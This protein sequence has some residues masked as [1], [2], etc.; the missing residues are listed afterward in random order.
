[1][2]ECTCNNM[3]KD[4]R[5]FHRP[6]S[7]LCIYYISKP[8]LSFFSRNNPT[9][10]P[11]VAWLLSSKTPHFLI[12]QPH[13]CSF[14]LPYPSLP[15]VPSAH[16]RTQQGTVLKINLVQFESRDESKRSVKVSSS[17]FERNNFFS[18]FFQFLCTSIRFWILNSV[19]RALHVTH[20]RTWERKV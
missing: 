15:R 6:I 20:T 9:S 7:L 11:Y 16:K 4:A 13:S 18:F 19:A 2:L 8:T 3:W 12:H 14:H 10:P 1:M 5:H 17:F